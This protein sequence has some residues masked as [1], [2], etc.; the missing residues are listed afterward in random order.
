MQNVTPSNETRIIEEAN[1]R[2]NAGL[3]E[4]GE[5]ANTVYGKTASAG[6]VGGVIYRN[7]HRIPKWHRI[8]NKGYHPVVGKEAGTRLRKDGYILCNGVIINKD[9]VESRWRM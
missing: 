7:R 4:F 1:R 8:T 3:V 6:I 9:D 2:T 5:I